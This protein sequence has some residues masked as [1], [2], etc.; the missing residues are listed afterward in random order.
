MKRDVM[1]MPFLACVIH[2]RFLSLGRRPMGLEMLPRRRTRA[3]RPASSSS[4]YFRPWRRVLN[5]RQYITKFKVERK[6]DKES[7]LVAH[8][9]VES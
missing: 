3:F 1:G 7:A 2:Q 6:R 8:D 5:L 9:S 4:S